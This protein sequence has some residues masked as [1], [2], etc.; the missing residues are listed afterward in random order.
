MNEKIKELYVGQEFANYRRL[1]EFLGVEIKCGQSKKSQL[2]DWA[3]YFCFDRDGNKIIIKKIYNTPKKKIDKGGGNHTGL[4]KYPELG[5][6]NLTK[7][8]K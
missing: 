2:K 5:V 1:C 4:C 6:Y 8:A 3:R 7:K